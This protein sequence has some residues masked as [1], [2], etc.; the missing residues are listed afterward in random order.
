MIGDPS[1][2]SHQPLPEGLGP[3][4]RW[5]LVEGARLDLGD[6]GVEIHFRWWDGGDARPELG[7]SVQYR[8]ECE[9]QVIRDKVCREPIATEEDRPAAEEADDE[10]GDGGV[11]CRVRLEGGRERQLGAVDVL[12]LHAGVEAGVG[13]G[14][15]EPGQEAGDG[16]HV[17]EPVEHLA[18]A[19]VDAHVRQQGKERGEDERRHGQP[20]AERLL[21]YRGCISCNC[22]AI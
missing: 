7:A 18:R 16:R 13:V 15:A 6:S 12:G 11:P 1:I 9:G 2:R 3:V 8:E 10:A 19:R 17:G 21:E 22:E 20:V 5:G 4:P 14:D